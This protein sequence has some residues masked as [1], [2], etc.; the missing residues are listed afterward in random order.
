MG[1]KCLAGISMGQNGG[2]LSSL[3]TILKASGAVEGMGFFVSPIYILTCDHVIR[4][5]GYYSDNRPIELIHLQT[6]KRF[7]AQVVH[8]ISPTREKIGDIALLKIDFS[9]EEQKFDYPRFYLEK[10]KDN[11]YSVYGFPKGTEGVWSY[12]M[13][14]DTT[15]VG[16]VQVED[17]EGKFWNATIK[18]GKVK[19]DRTK[20][21]MIQIHFDGFIKVLL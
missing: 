13:L 14:R 18:T 17:T 8:S 5:A 20:K 21:Q 9:F 3:V 6:K 2:L 15:H 16:L 1:L 11:R 12:G 19:E 7:T 4:N 10:L